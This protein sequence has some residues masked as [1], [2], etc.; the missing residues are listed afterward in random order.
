MNFSAIPSNTLF[1]KLLRWPLRLIPANSQ[2][3][4]LQGPLRGKKWIAGSSNHGC[5]FGSYELSKQRAFAAA[6]RPGHVVYDLGANVG[7]YSLLASVLVGP[8]GRV[9][10]FEPAPRNLLLLRKHL[11]LN[12]IINCT[13]YEA[14]VSD[15]KGFANFNPA[16][17]WSE[18]H[19][20]AESAN[21]FTVPT[22]S[23][24]GL[25]LSG[26]L[27]LPQVMKCDIE[28]AEYSALK[29]AVK[30]LQEAAPVIFL[31][32]HGSEVRR[33]CH[34]LLANLGYS[35]CSLDGSPPESASETLAL[36]SVKNP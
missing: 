33:N 24:D 6:L 10:S 23:L 30:V 29:G 27:P 4:V 15:S 8:Q 18:G 9:F 14:A 16:G 11:A 31:S 34:D 36:P 7:F 17:D 1:G 28:G 25:V 2:V 26:E 19:L 22:V 12:G 5:W 13:I 20:T 32:T 3:R 21:S 35:L